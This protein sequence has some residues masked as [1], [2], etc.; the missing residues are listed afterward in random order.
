[1]RAYPSAAYDAFSSLQHPTQSIPGKPTIA[2]S[3]GKA[4]SPATPKTLV[5]PR[6][7]SLDRTWSMT[8]VD[9]AFCVGTDSCN[10]P[11]RDTVSFV[12]VDTGDIMDL[13]KVLGSFVKASI[14]ETNYHRKFVGLRADSRSSALRAVAARLCEFSVPH[15][16]P[17]LPESRAAR[18]RR[19]CCSQSECQPRPRRASLA[20]CVRSA[21][22]DRLCY[23]VGRR[24][25]DSPHISR[26]PDCRNQ[27][28][29]CGHRE[30][31]A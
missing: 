22:V 16:N 5:I 6:S 3:M 24:I 10:I 7:L 17:R 18:F 8:V 13:L 25:R 19:S 21:G 31:L 26:C 28:R 14:C 23:L 11:V 30:V 2:S 15:F 29:M 12:A 9:F 20:I 27:Y 4:K 1:M